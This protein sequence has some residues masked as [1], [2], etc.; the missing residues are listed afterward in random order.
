[1][2]LAARMQLTLSFVFLALAAFPALGAEPDKPR[3][4]PLGE[5]LP[6][7][8]VL[9]LGS[10]RDSFEGFGS[11]AALSPDGKTI[12]IRRD[13]AL[14]LIDLATGKESKQIPLDDV[15]VTR[16]ITFSSTG[17]HLVLSARGNIYLF[18]LQAGKMLRTFAID[19]PFNLTYFAFSGDGKR[20]AI[21]AE[22][23]QKAAKLDVTVYDIDS[24]AKVQTVQTTPN[25]GAQVAL[26]ADGLR[27]ATWSDPSGF[28]YDVETEA[29]TITLWDLTNGKELQ[30]FHVDGY[31]TSAVALS[32]DGKELAAA[33]GTSSI[34]ILN[35]ETGKKVHRLMARRNGNSVSG[36]TTTRLLSYSPDGKVLVTGTGDGGVQMWQT[37]EY[38]PLGT[39]QGI[40]C[41]LSSLTFL[42][43]NKVLALGLSGNKVRLWEA[44]SGRVLVPL[45]S[46]RGTVT[47]LVFS[48]DG[49]NL[50][51][52]A[53]EGVRLWD[54]ATGKHVRYLPIRE[55]EKGPMM[56]SPTGRSVLT[57]LDSDS[58]NLVD[59]ATQQEQLGLE[60]P[61]I[62]GRLGPEC[63]AFSAD[64]A[65]LAAGATHIAAGGHILSLRVWHL[66]SGREGVLISQENG[67]V[68]STAVSPDGKFILTSRVPWDRSVGTTTDLTLWDATTGKARWKTE[69]DDHWTQRVA[70]SPD[71]RWVAAAGWE[72]ICI[73]EAA[74]G[75]E[76][77]AIKSPSRAEV[78]SLVF[79]ADSR[80]LAVGAHPRER[81]S[82]GVVWLW[83]TATGK[84]RATFTGHAGDVTALAFAPDG[85]LLASGGQDK[86]IL[87]W[88]LTGKFN[89]EVQSQTQPKPTDYDALWKDLDD[90]DAAK[91][92]RL[93]QGLTK[94][95]EAAAA[96]V[97]A[98]LPPVKT[99]DRAEIEKLIAQLDHEQFEQREKASKALAEIGQP[100]TA[101][102]TKALE[103][104]RSAEKKRRLQELL[105]A[106]NA[107]GPRPEMVRPA[108]ALEVLERLGTPAAKQLLEEL[109]NGD[110]DAAL[111]Q[112]ARAAV[113]RL[114]AH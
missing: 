38:R 109:A 1:M 100:A 9:R 86:T 63:T 56:L 46:H 88:D 26:S 71:G 22:S 42:P 62:T 12:A 68:F 78:S 8:A 54:A 102:L 106:L 5:P 40:E 10:R 30:K 32:P 20:F 44:P 61:T 15:L 25:R 90:A 43:E 75:S 81:G 85:R 107:K 110:P 82:E 80:M 4:D 28:G 52:G 45:V 73:L 59:L 2:S 65:T 11:A 37:P 104:T 95:P 83:E 19:N 21:G 92:Y 70:Y 3:L 58:L 89:R 96:L 18:D 31:G 50:L 66:D 39:V 34:S 84:Q 64:G 51:S 87:L 77:H 17:N 36:P 14:L 105:D 53:T 113:K 103:A 76:W 24:G 67:Q 99:R 35:V 69:W 111:T 55:G 94:Y 93:M 7:E 72:G 13:R 108:R 33:D 27:L 101:A 98:K 48:S 47:T 74:T 16:A 91:A 23:R 6:A 79:S 60:M 29:H 49:K 112:D 41:G 114:V 57:G 97:K